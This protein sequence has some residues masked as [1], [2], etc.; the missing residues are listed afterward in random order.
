MSSNLERSGGGSREAIDKR[1]ISERP[2]QVE[3]RL[4]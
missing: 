3:S 1:I 2:S 4:I